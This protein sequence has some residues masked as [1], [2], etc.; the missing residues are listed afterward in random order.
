MTSLN[1]KMESRPVSIFFC[2]FAPVFLVFW[3]LLVLLSV[4]VKQYA[5]KPLFEHEPG[6]Y[7]GETDEENHVRNTEWCQ[8][9]VSK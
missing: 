2:F 5:Y 6:S 4:E 8:S 1:S 9:R 3:L 7:G